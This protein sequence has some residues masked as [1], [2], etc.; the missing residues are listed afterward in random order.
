MK[1]GIMSFLF[2]YFCV[3]PYNKIV[4]G[5]TNMFSKNSFCK[6][7]NRARKTRDIELC[8]IIEEGTDVAWSEELWDTAFSSSVPASEVY[9]EIVKYLLQHDYFIHAPVYKVSD[10]FENIIKVDA[11][12]VIMEKETDPEDP[13]TM[14]YQHKFKGQGFQLIKENSPLL[15]G[16][17]KYIHNVV[18]ENSFDDYI[19][20]EVTHK[21]IPSDNFLSCPTPDSTV[22]NQYNNM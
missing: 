3:T 5:G 13:S 17:V 21:D 8:Q 9:D 16:E 12:I 4:T 11:S 15:T 6:L 10:L 14:Y 20:I 18:Q 22:F 1:Y 19:F 7:L 2:D